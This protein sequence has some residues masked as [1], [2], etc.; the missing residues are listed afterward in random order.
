MITFAVVCIVAG[1]VAYLAGLWAETK[2][3]NSKR[4]EGK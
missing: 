4:R 2:A 3:A 1:L